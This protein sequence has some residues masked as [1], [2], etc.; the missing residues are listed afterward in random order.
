MVKYLTEIAHVNAL[1]AGTGHYGNAQARFSAL[2][3]LE[4]L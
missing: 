1:S 4:F 3:R 2:H